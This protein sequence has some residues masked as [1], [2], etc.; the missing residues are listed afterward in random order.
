MNEEKKLLATAE[1]L[2]IFSII[3]SLG[4]IIYYGMFNFS[5]AILFWVFNLFV[6]ATL[7]IKNNQ[8]RGKLR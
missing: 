5:F 2:Q 8:R 4:F 1:K 3:L 6:N 7:F